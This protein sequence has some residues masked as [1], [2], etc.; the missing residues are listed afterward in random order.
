MDL[1]DTRFYVSSYHLISSTKSDTM[2]KIDKSDIFSCIN[3]K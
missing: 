1:I 3:L 2:H